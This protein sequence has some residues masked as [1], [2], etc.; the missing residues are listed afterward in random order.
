MYLLLLDI[1]MRKQKVVQEYKEGTWLR[2]KF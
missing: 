2:E 1:Y